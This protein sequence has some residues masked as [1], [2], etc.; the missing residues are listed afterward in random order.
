MWIPS[1]PASASPGRS[2]I[3]C[4]WP[5]LVHCQHHPLHQPYAVAHKGKGFQQGR[6]QNFP[7]STMKI[8]LLNNKFHGLSPFGGHHSLLFDQG[9]SFL[10]SIEV[11]IF[12]NQNLIKL[13]FF[14]KNDDFYKYQNTKE[15]PGWH[16]KAW[17][18]GKIYVCPLLFK[19]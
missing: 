3:L 2:Y 10:F 14:A 8:R 19:S 6:M 4:V 18:T 16:I 15:I 7:Y 5:P 11:V 13:T 1:R 9:V 17:D 12:W